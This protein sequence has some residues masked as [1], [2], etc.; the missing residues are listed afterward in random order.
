[1]HGVRGKSFKAAA[2]VAVLCLGASASRA[3]ES[4]QKLELRGGDKLEGKI[5][6]VSSRHVVF[7]GPGGPRFVERSSVLVAKES[8][9]GTIDLTA[10]ETN[11]TR[12]LCGLFLE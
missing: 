9:G 8:D 12:D 5:L 1:M 3:E 2:A 11:G 4:K 6:C 7:D 10:R